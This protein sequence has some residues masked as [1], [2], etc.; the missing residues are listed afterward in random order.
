MTINW[1]KVW[2]KFDKWL[3]NRPV[4]SLN[5]ERKKLRK[6]INKQLRKDEYWF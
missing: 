1:K 2:K 3:E 4:Y 6:I 5:E